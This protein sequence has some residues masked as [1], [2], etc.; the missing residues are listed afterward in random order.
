MR[1]DLR[2]LSS[3]ML[4]TNAHLAVNLRFLEFVTEQ[5]IRWSLYQNL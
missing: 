5:R 2:L 4:T 3:T 1:L